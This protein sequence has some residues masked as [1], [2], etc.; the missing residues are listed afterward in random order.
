MSEHP[1]LLLDENVSYPVLLAL[2]KR[3]WDVVHI[4]DIGMRTAKDPIVFEAAV[5]SGRVVLTSDFSDF[6]RLDAAFR[7]AGREHPGILLLPERPIGEIIRRVE[8]FD[9]SQIA[10]TIR[11]L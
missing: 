11:Y 6:K 2:R 1:A 9:F 3:A 8:T 4:K 7:I 10:S 5:E